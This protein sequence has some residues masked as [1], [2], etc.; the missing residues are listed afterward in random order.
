MIW[1]LPVHGEELE[2]DVTRRTGFRSPIVRQFIDDVETKPAQVL[3]FKWRLRGLEVGRCRRLFY[4]DAQALSLCF[5]DDPDHVP[6]ALGPMLHGVRHQLA[7]DQSRMV[8]SRSE[9]P[10][11]E[12]IVQRRPCE[13]GRFGCGGQD[14]FAADDEPFWTKILGFVTQAAQSKSVQ[15]LCY[16][17]NMTDI[18]PA[19]VL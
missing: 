3:G 2:P 14:H 7:Q 1:A 6:A 8:A 19:E 11:R 17:R 18:P 9:R 15:R 12:R 16:A 10:R 5:D 13:E 4:L